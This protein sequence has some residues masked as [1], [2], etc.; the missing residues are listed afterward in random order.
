MAGTIPEL[1][2]SRLSPRDEASFRLLRLIEQ[3]PN[4]TQ[5][6]LARAAGI[7]LGK[8]HYVLEA[9]I[10]RGF[11]K[12]E[13]FGSSRNKLAY[14]YVLTPSGLANKAAIAGRFLARKREEYDALRKEIEQ[15]ASEIEAGNSAEG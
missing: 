4:S 6:E 14:A 1:E 12:L 9:L 10:E 8:T 15:L 7:S 11:V 5:R 13:R 3:N 2:P